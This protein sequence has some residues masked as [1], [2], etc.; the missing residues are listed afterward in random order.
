MSDPALLS[1][2]AP[3][4]VP[5]KALDALDQA[6]TLVQ[7][8]ERSALGL[9]MEVAHVVLMKRKHHQSAGRNWPAYYTAKRKFSKQGS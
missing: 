3:Q 1:K 8:A 7:R 5:H 2:L 4:D 9:E 6:L